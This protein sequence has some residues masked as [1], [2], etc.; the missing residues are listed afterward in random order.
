VNK[1]ADLFEIKEIS[2]VPDSWASV[3]PIHQDAPMPSFMAQTDPS[4]I[5]AIPTSSASLHE[6]VLS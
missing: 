1:F 3:R 6:W 5:G 4:D 2:A